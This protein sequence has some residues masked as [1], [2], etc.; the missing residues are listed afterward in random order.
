M[1]LGLVWAAGAASVISLS[2]CVSTALPF[3]FLLGLVL[4]G[5]VLAAP[6][7]EVEG[8]DAAT[9]M[10]TSS[11]FSMLGDL[12]VCPTTFCF[13]A[14][15]TSPPSALIAASFSLRLLPDGPATAPVAAPAELADVVPPA[16]CVRRPLPLVADDPLPDALALA[17]GGGEGG[18]TVLG[19]VGIGSAS[20]IS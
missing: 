19:R 12:A 10:A 2:P 8:D 17:A 1:L 3:P 15:W 9:S 5:W 6:E 7:V 16:C 4:L 14:C 18:G 20:G 11:A 13:F